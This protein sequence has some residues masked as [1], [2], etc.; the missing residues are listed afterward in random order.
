MNELFTKLKDV[1]TGAI[2]HD[3]MGLCPDSI[4]GHDSRDPKCPACRVLIEAD[5]VC[6]VAE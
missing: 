4:E 3:Y 5:T 6:V 2:K 1:A